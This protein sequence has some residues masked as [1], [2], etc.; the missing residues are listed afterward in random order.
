MTS[1]LC[2]HGFVVCEDCAFERGQL[3]AITLLDSWFKEQPG[4]ERFYDTVADEL[5]E[6][7]ERTG[8]EEGFHDS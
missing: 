8:L 2:K 5:R 3:W 4:A 6:A 1:E 7:M